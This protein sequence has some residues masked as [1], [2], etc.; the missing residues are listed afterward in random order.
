MAKGRVIFR[1]DSCK[2]CGLC[3]GA[4]PKKIIFLDKSRINARGYNPAYVKDMDECIGCANC[5]MM[6]PDLVITVE[7]L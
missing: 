5:A 4:C 1:E 7:R 6:C 2:G 3:A